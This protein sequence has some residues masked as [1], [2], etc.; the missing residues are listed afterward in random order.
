[1]SLKIAVTSP[2]CWPYV[3]R[4]NRFAH[5][6]AAFLAERGHEVHFITSKPGGISR[7]KQRGKVLEE[8]HRLFCHPILPL[9]NIETWE[10]FFLNCFRSLVREDYDIVQTIWPP[11]G[12]AASL[13]RSIKGIPFVHLMV[14]SN[15]FFRPTA[16]GK[17]M[18][19]RILKTAA[20]LEVPSNYVYEELKTQLSMEGKLIPMPVNM[21]LFA[22]NGNKKPDQPRILC[23]SSFLDFR[24]RVHLLV[25]AFE[26]LLKEIPNAILQLS[27]HG[28]VNQA[29]MGLFKLVKPETRRSI[30]ILDVGRLEDM[31]RLYRQASLTVLPSLREAFGMVIIESLASG[32]PVVGTRSGAIP[33][34]LDNPG[35]GVLFEPTDTPQELCE[36][37]LKGLELSQDPQTPMRCRQH[38]A[39]YSWKELG[40]RYEALYMEVLNGHRR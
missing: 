5:E 36:A 18:L 19:R 16:L 7:K 22:P 17:P 38:A 29:A 9:F 30:E 28:T 3:R 11:D 15:Y 12:F 4:G 13:Y 39:P 33:E 27:G 24:K 10:T 35:V 2:F 26:L 23:T 37:L 31:P 32:T 40:P 20:S 25:L 6:L 8:Q 14:D 21:N 34:V 1:M